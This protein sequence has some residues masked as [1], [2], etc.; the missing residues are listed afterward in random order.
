[1]LN[2]VCLDNAIESS[3]LTKRI[4]TLQPL[5]HK[6]SKGTSFVLSHKIKAKAIHTYN[7]FCSQYEIEITV[8]L[9]NPGRWKLVLTKAY[10]GY[11]ILNIDYE[12]F[13][14]FSVIDNVAFVDLILKR[15]QISIIRHGLR[16]PIKI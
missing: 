14:Q 9:N 3:P 4:I 6:P 1:M 16:T 2:Q 8:M 7:V 5:N 10:I 13:V 11:T 15:M 12:Q